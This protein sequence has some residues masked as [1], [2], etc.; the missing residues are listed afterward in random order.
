MPVI[1]EYEKLTGLAL[2]ELSGLKALPLPTKRINRAIT[3]RIL[4]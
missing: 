1:K 3:A 4:W 2:D